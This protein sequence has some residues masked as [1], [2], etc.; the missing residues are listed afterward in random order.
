MNQK[1][2]CHKD[3]YFNLIYGGFIHIISQRFQKFQH[4]LDFVFINKSKYSLITNETESYNPPHSINKLCKF[5]TQI[6]CIML[7]YL[8]IC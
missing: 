7:S 8:D 3:K 2:R 4:Y 5:R 6:C 1:P